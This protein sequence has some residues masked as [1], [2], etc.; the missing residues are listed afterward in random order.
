MAGFVVPTGVAQA[1]SVAVAVAQD[2]VTSIAMLQS[3]EFSSFYFSRIIYCCARCGAQCGIFAIPHTIVKKLGCSGFGAA[4]AL[5][6]QRIVIRRRE[7]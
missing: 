4:K 1:V 7:P 5:K 6:L 2:H 3:G